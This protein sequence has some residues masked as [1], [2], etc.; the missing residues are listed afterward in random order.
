MTKLTR[1]ELDHVK[2]MRK[3]L[4]QCVRDEAFGTISNY[5]RDLLGY[6]ERLSGSSEEVILAR[7]NQRLNINDKV[8]VKLTDFGRACLTQHDA[9]CK[10]LQ[11]LFKA[12]PKEDADG[13]SEWQLWELMSTFGERLYNGCEVPFEPTIILGDKI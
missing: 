1:S 6:V 11:P 2:A 7:G 4:D 3:N 8:R 12:M 9:S 5:C 13:Y 10:D